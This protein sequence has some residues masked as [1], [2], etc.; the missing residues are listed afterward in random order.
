MESDGR[1]KPDTEAGTNQNR[2]DGKQNLIGQR[3]AAQNHQHRI[4]D[5]RQHDQNRQ[6]QLQ[7][8]FPEAARKDSPD[9][10][11]HKEGRQK[12]KIR[13]RNADDSRILS[14]ERIVGEI[15]SAKVRQRKNQQKHYHN[16]F[17]PL[18]VKMKTMVY[19][20][21]PSGQSNCLKFNSFQESF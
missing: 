18:I 1:Y 17:P 13:T 20:S 5:S 6:Y 19:S 3:L 7:R 9:E 10:P 16:T 4:G 14:A 11:N 21:S 12:N 2:R 8:R 15:A